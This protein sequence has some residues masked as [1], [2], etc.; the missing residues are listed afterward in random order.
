MRKANPFPEEAKFLVMLAEES[1]KQ[2]MGFYDLHALARKYKRLPPRT[3]DVLQKLDA[4]RTHFSLTGI[5]T[6]KS[7]EDV[8]ELFP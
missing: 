1:Q 4:V 8:L 7:V 5:K 2:F 6:E 3:N